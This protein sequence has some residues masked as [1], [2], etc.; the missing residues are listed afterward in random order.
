MPTADLRFHDATAGLLGRPPRLSA[1]AVRTIEDWEAR[2]GLA[3]PAAV[4]EWYTL[5]GCDDLLHGGDG[6]YPIP[7]E[8]VLA[9]HEQVVTSPEA[10]P[11]IRILI[12]ERGAFDPYHEWDL[13]LDG[14][15]DPPVHKVSEVVPTG[16]VD[17][18]VEAD[19]FSA[20]A[21]GRAWDA[22]PYAARAVALGQP[23][24]CPP[25]LDELIAAFPEAPR[26]SGEH[27]T[28]YR[29]HGPGGRLG[30]RTGDWRD[31]GAIADWDLR[32][33]SPDGLEQLARRVW[34]LGALGTALQSG[35]PDGQA[36]L[37][38]LRA[39]SGW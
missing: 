35:D 25:E 16:E 22:L 23:A 37:N 29:F 12:G 27:R 1:T 20:F 19:H 10:L 33:D 15:D 28:V 11:R 21:F 18:F 6:S 17:A 14:S 38:R 13:H 32:S 5:E 24:L 7:L 8:D 36:V 34:H 3:L 2:R 9:T 26:Q 39:G 4:R 31:G 30:V